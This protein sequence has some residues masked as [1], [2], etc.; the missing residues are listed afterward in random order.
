[1]IR[2]V[3]WSFIVLI[4]CYSEG[5]EALLRIQQV[6]VHCRSQSKNILEEQGLRFNR[7]KA[8]HFN[9][10]RTFNVEGRWYTNGGV[11]F[12]ECEAPFGGA[13]KTMTLIVT[14]ENNSG[15]QSTDDTVL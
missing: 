7:W 2:K 8:Q 14:K 3:C 4:A 9:G 12:V 1:M 15:Y 13:L 11:Y 6:E 10:D 5:Q